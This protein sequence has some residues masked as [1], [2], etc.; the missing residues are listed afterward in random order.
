MIQKLLSTLLVLLFVAPLLGQGSPTPVWVKVAQEN[1]TVTATTPITYR[2]GVPAGAPV[3]VDGSAPCVAPG[4]CWD[5]PVTS[6]GPITIPVTVATFGGVDPAYG[7]VKQLQVLQTSAAQAVADQQAG[8]A[9]VNVAIPAL[10][11]A[12]IPAS[13]GQSYPVTLSIEEQTASQ[14]SPDW[15]GLFDLP[16]SGANQ[17]YEG[18]VLR[19]TIDGVAFQCAY[20]S[21]V[22]GVF[23]LSCVVPSG[24]DEAGT[25]RKM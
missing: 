11:P 15:I 12:A 24:A 23:T 6:T 1:D 7:T 19:L 2:F 3:A 8:G 17:G 16:A 10:P 25:P 5:T 9:V 20:G 21:Q 22:S 14:A 4:G 13:P 18:T